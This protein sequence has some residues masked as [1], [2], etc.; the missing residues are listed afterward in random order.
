MQTALDHVSPCSKSNWKPLRSFIQPWSH[1][2]CSNDI[3]AENGWKG[4]RQETLKS[5]RN[6][7]G[8]DIM[9]TWANMVAAMWR[10]VSGLQNWLAVVLAWLG[11][12]SESGK[13]S[14]TGDK[15]IA[16]FHSLVID[17]CRQNIL[18]DEK[19]RRKRFGT[20]MDELSYGWVDGNRQVEMASWQV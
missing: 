6:Y 18:C 16:Q 12:C 4:E 2:N 17:K 15:D 1:A 3:L 9:S 19:P 11:H 7:C 8:W 13:R 10:E 14:K 5:L 20:G